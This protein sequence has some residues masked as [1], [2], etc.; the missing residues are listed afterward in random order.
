MKKLVLL[1]ET[2]ELQFKSRGVC[3]FGSRVNGFGSASSD[4]DLTILTNSFVSERKCL[5]NLKRKMEE[6]GWKEDGLRIE[7]I[8]HARVPFINMKDT[9]TG[10]EVDLIVNN[11][12]GLL[13]SCLIRIYNLVS[14]KITVLGV[15]VKEWAKVN[16]L[17]S[18]SRLSSYAFYLI[19]FHFLIEKG[20]TQSLLPP[21]ERS[22]ILCKKERLD[23]DANIQVYF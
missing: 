1:L 21:E 7:F 13:N 8:E 16:G 17:V 18:N 20:Y 5:S 10:E 19:M 2:Q 15:L 4:F 22:T 6:Q 14:R 23:S 3:Q 12:P 9:R 11:I